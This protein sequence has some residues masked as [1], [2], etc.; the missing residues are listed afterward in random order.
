MKNTPQQIQIEFEKI[1]FVYDHLATGLIINLLVGGVLYWVMWDIT[2]SIQLSVWFL[3]LL[4]VVLLRFTILLMYRRCRDKTTKL[5]HWKMMFTAGAFAM[6]M[7]WGGGGV[8]LFPTDAMAQQIFLCFVIGGMVMG[9]VPYLSPVIQAYALFLFPAILPPSIF[10][11][12]T[13]QKL[14][15]LLGI[16]MLIFSAAML[17]AARLS[18]KNFLQNLMLRFINQDLVKKLNET[19]N[20]LELK[21]DL[22]NRIEQDLREN[23]HRFKALSNAAHDGVILHKQGIVIEANEAVAR[24]VGRSVQELIGMNV[25]ELVAA[26]CREDIKQRLSDPRNDT[27][28]TIGLHKDGST[29]RAELNPGNVSYQGD[30]AR[31]VSVRDVSKQKQIE[32]NLLRAKNAAEAADKLKSE[33]LA[34]V[35][36]EIRTPMNAVLGFIQILEETPLTS[37]Q[38]EYLGMT[39]KA[40]S[41]LLLLINDLL[42]LSRIETG[43][44]EFEHQD[45]CLKT[46]LAETI[47][48][49]SLKAKESESKLNLE[50][51]GKV[52]DWVRIDPDRLRQV[53]TNLLGNAIKFSDKDSGVVRLS[54]T[55]KPTAHGKSSLYFEVSDNGIG[56]PLEKQKAIFQ[57]FTQL[58]ASTSRKYGGAGLGLAISRELIDKMGGEIGVISQMGAGSTFWFTLPCEEVNEP[59]QFDNS[60][61]DIDDARDSFKGLSIL[62]VED[63][64]TNQIIARHM[65]ER[66]GCQVDIV[67]NGQQAVDNKS[68]YDLIFM[69]LQMPVLDGIEATK[70]LHENGLTTPVIAMTANAMPGDRD[71]CLEAGMDDYISKP[72]DLARLV[73]VLS[74]WATN[75][76]KSASG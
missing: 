25:L 59:E 50:M 24:M 40:A 36:H 42:D 7:V 54:V 67:S 41:Q 5:V 73:V 66:L 16:V 51:P 53:L 60:I 19:N 65:F 30:H 68:I 10:L 23:E 55:T 18:Q 72:I 13:G 47:Q 76:K 34:S 44:F 20:D 39:R 32:A 37:E 11:L 75:R 4:L 31:I 35:S 21:I 3:V 46:F 14:Y 63:E 26:E 70:Q 49:M 1:N 38:Q 6:G 58:D 2:A 64:E 48:M 29:F 15:Q 69:D 28:E 17:I 45:I 12:S 74:R 61:A 52:P 9:A 71:R 43:H 8:V 22:K 56:I 27:F 62:L 33:F 57:R